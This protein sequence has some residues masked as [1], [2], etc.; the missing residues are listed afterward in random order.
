MRTEIRAANEK[1]IETILD[2]MKGYY[3]YDNLD[4]SKERSRATLH[5]F[6]NSNS[7]S[8]FVIELSGKPIGYFCLSYGYSLELHGKDCFL[9]EIYLLPYY[10]QQGIGTEVLQFIEIFV[11]KGNFK[12]VHLI[13]FEKNIAA[14]QFYIKNGFRTR[15]A[16][17]MTKSLSREI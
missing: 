14:Q 1:D 6:I 10:R 7:G 4:Y 8:L 9:D 11:K 13:V 5:E 12:S 17:F 16:I 3:Q 15:K 2:L